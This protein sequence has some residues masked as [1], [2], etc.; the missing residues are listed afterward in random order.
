MTMTHVSELFLALSSH[1]R[2]LPAIRAGLA[3][4]GFSHY[5]PPTKEKVCDCPRCLSVCLL[6]R[7]LKSARMN[8]DEIL[9]VNRCRD[10]D[11][12]INF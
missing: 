4:V 9:L 5:L 8:L 6:A 3:K 12:L 11:E 1:D 7:L 2:Q 10:T